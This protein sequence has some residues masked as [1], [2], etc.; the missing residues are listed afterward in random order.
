MAMAMAMAMAFLGFDGLLEGLESKWGGELM[1]RRMFADVGD[2]QR[3][4][5]KE[6]KWNHSWNEIQVSEKI[7]VS[8]ACLRR[9]RL[10][11]GLRQDVKMGPPGPLLVV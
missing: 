4:Q 7:Q 2:D 1:M 11:R 9:W 5:H 10:R 3:M 8:L 6:N